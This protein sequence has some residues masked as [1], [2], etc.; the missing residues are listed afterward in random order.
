[1]H[2]TSAGKSRSLNFEGAD[3]I[4]F[5]ANDVSGHNALTLAPGI[6]YKFSECVQVGTAVEFPV[7]G[8]RRDLSDFRW[9]VDL[10]FRY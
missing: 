4:N 1:M 5:G 6:R 2:Y 9:T 8:N 10:I 7:T 3:L